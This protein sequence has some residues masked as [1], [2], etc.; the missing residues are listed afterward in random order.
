MNWNQFAES[1]I[2]AVLAIAF[3]VAAVVL[4]VLHNPVPADLWT[5]SFA[6]ATYAAGALR[7][8]A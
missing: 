6:S 8:S 1:I 2:G 4:S 3:L 5:A 7:K